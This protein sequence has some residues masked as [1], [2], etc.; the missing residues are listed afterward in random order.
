MRGFLR[1]LTTDLWSGANLVTTEATNPVMR[2]DVAGTELMKM[3]VRGLVV[4]RTNH[5]RTNHK[6][7]LVA[8]C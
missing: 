2:T 5:A 6:K 3:L 1:E 8:D 4:M 7:R